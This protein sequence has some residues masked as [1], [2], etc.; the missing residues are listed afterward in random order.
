MMRY[1][2]REYERLMKFRFQACSKAAGRLIEQGFT[3]LDLTG[4][5]TSILSGS[6]IDILIKFLL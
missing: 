3:I 1:Y 2:I 6:V 4:V 5:S